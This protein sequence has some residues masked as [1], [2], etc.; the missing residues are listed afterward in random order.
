MATKVYNTGKQ[1]IL[2]GWLASGADLRVILCMTNTTAD[3]E[4]DDI[5]YVDDIATL[6]EHDGD[7]Y[8]RKALAS[9]TV[10]KDDANDRASLGVADLVY[11]N[12]GAGARSI[13]GCIIYRHATDDTDSPV[14]M[15]HEFANPLTP[16]GN[17]Y[18]IETNEILRAL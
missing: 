9:E 4:N 10:T 12:L 8:E 3:T 6:D 2:E 17:T 18:T 14:I 11:S 16:D 5:V 1:E 7:N 13:A 15:W